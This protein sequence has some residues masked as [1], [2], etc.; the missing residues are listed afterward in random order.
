MTLLHTSKILNLSETPMYKM[1]L[2]PT[3]KSCGYKIARWPGIDAGRHRDAGLG[4]G[5][6]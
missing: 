6:I 1:S 2:I 5:R 3:L 4:R